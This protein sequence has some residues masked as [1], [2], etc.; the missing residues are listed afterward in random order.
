[1]DLHLQPEQP[2]ARLVFTKPKFGPYAVTSLC[3]VFAFNTLNTVS[4]GGSSTLP[5]LNVRATPRSSRLL[6]G[7][8]NFPGGSSVT[9]WL[10]CTRVGVIALVTRYVSPMSCNPNVASE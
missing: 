4:W 7:Y 1:M 3:T 8:E 10:V 9:V 5:C 2:P 6:R